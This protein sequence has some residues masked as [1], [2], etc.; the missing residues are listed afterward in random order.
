MGGE[1]IELEKSKQNGNVADQTQSKVTSK[2][3]GNFDDQTQTKVTFLSTPDINFD[4]VPE[5]QVSR[6]HD[7]VIEIMDQ[8]YFKTV[9]SAAVCA[10]KYQLDILFH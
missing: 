3:D 1:Q 2:D 6:T 4:Y 7:D 5:E 9:N 10:I 8:E